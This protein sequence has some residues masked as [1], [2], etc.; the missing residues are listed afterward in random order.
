MPHSL[1]TASRLSDELAA[2][3]HLGQWLGSYP[4]R[5]GQGI[6]SLL[7]CSFMTISMGIISI[8]LVIAAVV[9]ILVNLHPR[10]IGLNLLILLF[11][12]LFLVLFVWGS[13][14]SLKWS[15]PE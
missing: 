8:P 14:F 1:P 5:R 4:Y 7:V 10:N 2:Q 11:G 13:W 6:L 15:E 12:V 3:Q 9:A